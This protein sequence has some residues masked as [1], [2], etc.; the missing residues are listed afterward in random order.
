MTIATRNDEVVT[1]HDRAFLT[2]VPGATVR[3]TSS[4]QV[5]LDQSERQPAVQQERRADRAQ[6]ARPGA[7]RPLFCYAQAPVV[8]DPG[9]GLSE[10]SVRQDGDRH[11][12]RRPAKPCMPISFAS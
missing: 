10:G 9:G 11:L 3:T 4:G 8:A 5:R 12:V 6:Q 1:P 2:A 7:T